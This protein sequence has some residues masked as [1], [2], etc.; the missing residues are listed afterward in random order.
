MTF[1][2]VTSH[3]KVRLNFLF[4][5]TMATPCGWDGSFLARSVRMLL[6]RIIECRNMAVNYDEPRRQEIFA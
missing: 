1:L 6:K 2:D 5:G 3:P 4:I